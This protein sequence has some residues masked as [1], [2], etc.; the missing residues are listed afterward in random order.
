MAPPFVDLTGKRFGRLSVLRMT[1]DR[2]S[3]QSF[4]WL[5]RCDCG[6][7]KIYERSNL[8]RANSCGC[9]VKEK[10][11]DSLDKRLSEKYI[12][13]PNSGCWLW[14]G[15]M[16]K[17]NGYGKISI[18]GKFHKAHRTMFELHCGEIPEGFEVCHSCDVPSCVNPDHLFAG[19]HIDNM[20][21]RDRKGRRIAP[22]GTTNGF[23]KLTDETVRAIRAA[24]TGTQEEIAQRFGIDQTNV[25]LILRGKRWAHVT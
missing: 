3:N 15:G 7:E 19:T 23:A 11:R 9:L 12:P 4:R 10:S 17:E 14:L 8:R 25:S 5:C 22:K 16:T 21:D 2:S 24:A 6:S 1:N 13:E 18:D 20:A